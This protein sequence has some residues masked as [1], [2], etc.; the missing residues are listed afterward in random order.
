MHD[1]MFS[2]IFVL[3]SVDS[4]SFVLLFSVVKTTNKRLQIVPGVTW[5]A[6]SLPIAN[7]YSDFLNMETK[8]SLGFLSSLCNMGRQENSLFLT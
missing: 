3:C 1:R 8:H 6:K 2:G 7:H 5:G 4:S